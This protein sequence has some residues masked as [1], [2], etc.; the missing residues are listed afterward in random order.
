M[1]WRVLEEERGDGEDAPGEPV[2]AA[3]GE[4]E[5]AAVGE[6]EAVPMDI[7]ETQAGERGDRHMMILIDYSRSGIAIE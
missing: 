2:E 7:P 4:R 6:G 5:E 3:V 1:W